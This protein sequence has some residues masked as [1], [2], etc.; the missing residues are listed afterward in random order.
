MYQ[1]FTQNRF[2]SMLSSSR[3]LAFTPVVRNKDID[4]S[5]TPHN[6]QIQSVTGEKVLSQFSLKGASLNILMSLDI[7]FKCEEFKCPYKHF[8]PFL[9]ISESIV[10]SHNSKC[11]WSDL[12]V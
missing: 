3:T 9:F 4:F 6:N 5:S 1:R 11:I 7:F 8:S 10:H 2:K 12:V